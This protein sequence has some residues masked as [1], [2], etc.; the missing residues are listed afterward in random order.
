MPNLAQVV[1]VVRERKRV[2]SDFPWF[3]K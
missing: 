1:Q 3:L 2:R